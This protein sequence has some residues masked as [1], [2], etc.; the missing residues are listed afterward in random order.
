M[1]NSYISANS[2]PKILKL[3]ENITQYFTPKYYFN[4]LKKMLLFISLCISRCYQI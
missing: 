1:K 3:G 2:R 4:T